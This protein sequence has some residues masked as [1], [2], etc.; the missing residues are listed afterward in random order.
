MIWP[1]HPSGVPSTRLVSFGPG[2]LPI[3][4]VTGRVPRSRRR[5]TRHPRQAADIAFIGR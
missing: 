5:I 1:S 2:Q 3:S 4:A